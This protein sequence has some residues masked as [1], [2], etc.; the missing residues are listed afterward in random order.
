[1]A[2]PVAGAYL[3][4]NVDDPLQITASGTLVSNVRDQGTGANDFGQATDAN[5]PSL[6]RTVFG[7]AALNFDGAASYLIT[8]G[9]PTLTGPSTVYWVFTNDDP[10][11]LRQLSYVASAAGPVL[12]FNGGAYVIGSPPG[13]EVGAGTTDSGDHVVS[14]VLNDA[15]SGAWVDGVSITSS[16]LGLGSGSGNPW[17]LGAYPTPAF[18]FDGAL[19]EL[20]VFPSAHTTTERQAMEGYLRR[21]ADSYPIAAVEPAFWGRQGFVTGKDL[22]FQLRGAEAAISSVT[23]PQ[24]LDVTSTQSA[25][26]TR[27]NSFLRTLSV[28][29]TGTA[30]LTRIVNRI[31]TLSV[32][33][34]GTATMTRSVQKPLS[35]TSTQTPTMTRAVAK[36]L[37]VTSTATATLTRVLTYA[38]TLSAVST[39]TATISRIVSYLRTLSATST[40]TA[41]ITRQVSKTLSAISTSTPVLLAGSL[42]LR[43][44]SATS[45]AVATLTK[46]S[47][48]QRTLSVV[49]TGT[50]TLVRTIG[51]ILS[52][53]SSGTPELFPIKTGG[54]TT[55]QAMSA[56]STQTA[57]LLIE[58]VPAAAGGMLRPGRTFAEERGPRRRR[59]RLEEIE[60]VNQDALALMLL[61]Q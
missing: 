51:K 14:A 17:L 16:N 24:S 36:T 47:A 6:T 22:P 15:S 52:V 31:R 13:T 21:P 4:L 23:T 1:V 44:L 49:S 5:K 18:F 19:T 29:S 11:G 12:Y 38:R 34:T 8:A 58:L 3:W 20:A 59:L 40:A 7:R 57:E 9:S 10:A 33:S 39:G 54:S 26:L 37:S 42:Y 35:V 32:T 30:T 61:N 2:L 60:K 27:V 50:A 53:T 28:T 46:T 25:T 41:T 56:V 48:Y 43:T 45:T 55:P